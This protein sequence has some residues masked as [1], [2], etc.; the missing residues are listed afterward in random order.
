MKQFT[1]RTLLIITFFVSATALTLSLKVLGPTP[2]STREAELRGEL[3][4]LEERIKALTSAIEAAGEENAMPAFL[5]EE[6]TLELPPETVIDPT[7]D[8]R[9]TQ[10]GET[11][12]D[13]RWTMALRGMMPPTPEHIDRSR[14]LLFDPNASL[15]D[16]LAALRILRTSDQLTDDDVRQMV[17]IFNQTENERAQ[18]EIIRRLDDVRTPEFLDTLMAVSSTSENARVR[19]EAID[20]LSGYLPDPDLK[21]WLEVVSKD[22]PNK[23]VQREANRLLQQY[24]PAAED[25]G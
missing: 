16:Q 14:S 20:S 10:I 4:A 6:P 5:A 7:T 12:D 3:D 9:V 11:M 25:G 15:R 8:A 13:V 23:R 24:W 1:S 21:D 18:V 2:S 19:E 22:D 17:S